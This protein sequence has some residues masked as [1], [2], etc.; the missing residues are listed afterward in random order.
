MSQPRL[1]V[2][3][4][5]L[6]GTANAL[7]I[8]WL[9]GFAL[10]AYPVRQLAHAQDAPFALVRSMT[11]V[12]SDALAA[13]PSLRALATL[14]SGVDHVDVDLLAARAVRLATGRGGN[15]RAVADW[16][17]WALVRLATP[18]VDRS[19]LA[20]L[21]VLVVGVGAVGSVV[22]R[23]LLHH[24]AQVLLHDPPRAQ[25]SPD[26]PAELPGQR[27]LALNQLE[28]AA[29]DAL[30][31]HVPLVTDGPYPTRNWLSASRLAQ[32]S[33]HP[34]GLIVLQ[35]SRGGVVEEGA[36]AALRRS[37]RLRGLAMDTWCNEPTPAAEVLA[38]ADLAT[39]HLAGHSAQGKL[40]VAARAVTQLRQLAGL[41]PALDLPAAVA[42]RL[43][44]LEHSDPWQ[45][46]DVV[47][48]AFARAPGDF[49]ALRHRHLRTEGQS[50]Q[51]MA[52]VLP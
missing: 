48:A 38:A 15:A 45:A 24:G 30:T 40:D 4:E 6:A 14:S 32:W 10:Q 2:D 34:E 3:R 42:A 11:H 7:P 20:G 13:L 17:H 9:D 21:R 23:L 27:W 22:A 5:V 31:L 25:R 33:G 37:G 19:N 52:V 50:V 16:C 29:F 47:A 8:G 41:D 51:S 44:G 49:V 39:P 28:D 1:L 46:L 43:H 26:G 35:A 18:E 36:A 12:G